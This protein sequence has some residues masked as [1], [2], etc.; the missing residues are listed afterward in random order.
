MIISVVV[1]FFWF[2]ISLAFVVFL[3]K[4]LS[5][6]LLLLFDRVCGA[7]RLLVVHADI[8]VPLVVWL[9]VLFIRR[10]RRFCCCCLFGVF[11][12]CLGW[13]FA[14]LLVFVV[15]TGDWFWPDWWFG[16]EFGDET[17]FPVQI[18]PS[19]LFWRS[20]FEAV[21]VVLLSL[22]FVGFCDFDFIEIGVIFNIS[23]IY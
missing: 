21:V 19:E 10:F 20:S 8:I 18:F 4:L 15:F 1:S 14:G 13:L 17:P 7:Y 16:E 6:L 2:R 9:A 3:Y 11:R 5:L 23:N 22:V 12:L